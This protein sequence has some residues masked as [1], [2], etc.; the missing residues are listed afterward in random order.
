[1]D[2]DDIDHRLKQSFIDQKLKFLSL[3][4]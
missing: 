3:I 1:M 2:A 4:H